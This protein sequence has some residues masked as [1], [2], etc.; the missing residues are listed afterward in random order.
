MDDKQHH[1]HGEN[2]FPIFYHLWIMIAGI[3]T[4]LEEDAQQ[5]RGKEVSAN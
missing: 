2:Q 5:F 1:K 4:I 3:Q